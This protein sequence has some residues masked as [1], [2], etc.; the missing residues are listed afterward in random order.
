MDKDPCHCLTL[1][2]STGWDFIVASGVRPPTHKRLFLFTLVFP[3]PSLF[4]VLRLFH[5]SL[6]LLSTTYLDIAM[7]S[8]VSGP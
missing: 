8:S 5:F 2:S 3:V 6:S 4:T 1:S 7:A